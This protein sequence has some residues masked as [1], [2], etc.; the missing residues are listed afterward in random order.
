MLVP[1]FGLLFGRPA[2]LLIFGGLTSLAVVFD[3]Y[4][5]KRAPMPFAAFFAGLGFWT[6]LGV[7]GV[8]FSALA[9]KGLVAYSLAVFA[10]TLIA[11]VVGGAGGGFYGYRLGVARGHKYAYLDA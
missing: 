10:A 9:M 6:V 3:K 5:S 11:T 2:M 7:S 4:A 8:L 1:L